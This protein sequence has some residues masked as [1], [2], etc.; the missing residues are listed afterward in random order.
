[1][2]RKAESGCAGGAPAGG[3]GV[4][5][6]AMEGSPPG[7]GASGARPP[8]KAQLGVARTQRSAVVIAG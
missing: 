4:W 6:G 2:R 5:A 3:G 1:M 7:L 8:D